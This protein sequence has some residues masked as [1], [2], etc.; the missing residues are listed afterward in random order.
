MP[1]MK[2]GILGI[3]GEGSLGFTFSNFVVG[4]EEIMSSL[5][6]EQIL[7]RGRSMGNPDAERKRVEKHI[8]ETLFP[9]MMQKKTAKY[10]S[11]VQPATTDA[12]FDSDV[13]FL[14]Y[15]AYG[16]HSNMVPFWEP[17]NR[18]KFYHM[19]LK[20][21][22]DIIA[23]IEKIKGKKLKD[24]FKGQVVFATNPSF[25]LANAFLEMTGLDPGQVIAL[26][27]DNERLAMKLRKLASEDNCMGNDLKKHFNKYFQTD[28]MATGE[29]GDNL[30]AF[31]P[32]DVLKYADSIR[33][34]LDVVLTEGQD[35]LSLNG[36]TS[37]N[38]APQMDDF[39]N[40]SVNGLP[41]F[42]NWGV[43]YDGV[44]C[45]LPFVNRKKTIG[46]KE[47]LRAEIIDDYVKD[48]KSG[49]RKLIFPSTVPPDE[50]ARRSALGL[51][52]VIKSLKQDED[53]LK[54]AGARFSVAVASVIGSGFMTCGY[55][56][57][58]RHIPCKG[59]IILFESSGRSLAAI[60]E[61]AADK[62]R[63]EKCIVYWSDISNAPVECGID[64]PGYTGFA[65][66]THSFA[67]D[68]DGSCYVGT[69]FDN[70]G[71]IARY[72]N[73]APAGVE[74]EKVLPIALAAGND[75]LY[76]S[77]GSKIL[78]LGK[79]NLEVIVDKNRNPSE[80]PVA[81][82]AKGSIINELYCSCNK[83]NQI[84]FAKTLSIN[85][86]SGVLAW[87]NGAQLKLSSSSP[88]AFEAALAGG[89]VALFYADKNKIRMELAGEKTAAQELYLDDSVDINSLRFDSAM[90]Y[91]YASTKNQ[92]YIIPFNPIT[93][94][95]IENTKEIRYIEQRQFGN[96]IRD[97]RVGA[98]WS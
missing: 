33:E 41:K 50:A 20:M 22:K 14:G 7:L 95:L 54:K 58:K 67:L 26:S 77:T 66:T 72:K 84:L 32:K 96:E 69:C 93:H 3:G 2:I 79:E 65:G 35:I 70:K 97:F 18:Q 86:E 42:F 4:N 62:T 38:V 90:N 28:I 57:E 30:A 34:K 60:V 44:F 39:L 71:R 56:S 98:L 1:G 17:G 5:N 68:S 49:S 59:D 80:I 40:A 31:L 27:P 52:W 29:H 21:T 24:F 16:M 94:A 43:Y 81:G 89:K 87:L 53:N 51:D 36:S 63:S 55:D 11:K 23:E 10:S 13:I 6:L 64:T 47:V 85:S 15:S 78:R 19:N 9:T 88:G 76:C 12:L 91:L 74:T 75:C 61:R 48:F 45:T 73:G 46:G 8:A 83:N 37:S 25:Q 92:I 82:L